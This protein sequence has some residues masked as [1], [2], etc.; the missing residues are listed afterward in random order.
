MRPRT[1]APFRISRIK[2]KPNF[3]VSFRNQETGK[4]MCPHTTHTADKTEAW[5]VAM[6]WL[7]N[8]IPQKGDAPSVK[9]LSLLNLAR[10]ADLT[11]TEAALIAKELLRRGYLK[12]FVL[13]ESKADTDFTEFLQDFWD[14]DRSPY[15]QEKLRKKHG[16]HHRYVEEQQQVIK[17][18]WLP[19][20]QGK[21]LGDITRQDI[22]D[23]INHFDTGMP[24]GEA[25]IPQSAKRKNITWVFT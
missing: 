12:T 5:K 25:V 19:Y 7:Q 20:F 22:E 17:R 16:I 15:V 14:F 1:T 8:G 2:G 18:F 24:I 23:Y 21:L 9:Q 13:A 4:F 6:N 11:P 10:K 3:Y